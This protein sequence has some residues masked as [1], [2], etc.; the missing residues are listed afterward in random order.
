MRTKKV[1]I[2]SYGDIY[3]TT[4]LGRIIAVVIMIIG[5]GFVG[6][7]SWILIHIK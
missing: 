1:G 7:L 6:M 3:P 2:I 5:L 4:S